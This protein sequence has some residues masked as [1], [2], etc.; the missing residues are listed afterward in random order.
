[1]YDKTPVYPH[2]QHL[3]FA[4]EPFKSIYVFQRL[5]TTILL[6]PLWL[7]YY[8][9]LP[10]S[11]RP[12]PSW[13]ITQI[14]VVKFTKR[15]YKVTE[16]AGVTWGTRD[17]TEEPDEKSLDETRF[18]WVPSLPD[19]LCTGI[20]DDDQVLRQRVGTFIWPKTLPPSAR[21]RNVIKSGGGHSHGQNVSLFKDIPDDSVTAFSTPAS[22]YK[23]PKI[24]VRIEETLP[25][26]GTA[27]NDIDVEA[28][29]ANCPPHVIGLYLHGGGYCHMSAHEKSGTS[30]IPRRL[31]K[32]RI[33]IFGRIYVVM[34]YSNRT[35]SSK[36]STVRSFDW[37]GSSTLTF[38]PAVEYRLIQHAPVPGAIQDAAAVYAHLV[39]HH[40]GARKG[41]DGKYNYPELPTPNHVHA[42]DAPTLSIVQTLDY[43]TRPGSSIPSDTEASPF[44][45]TGDRRRVDAIQIEDGQ[46]DSVEPRIS[47]NDAIPHS[48]VNSVHLTQAKSDAAAAAVRPHII[49]IGD[50]AG[51]NLVLALA[52]WIRDEGVLPAPDGILLL[53]PSCDPCTYRHMVNGPDSLT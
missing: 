35:I 43:E 48:P 13:S 6:V 5:L 9:I 20:V 45:E 19:E 14:I 47:G 53:S 40:L 41:P 21:L 8:S 16:V 50:S 7:V 33:A 26:L 17:P 36:R 25:Y 2:Q 22:Q 46:P 10:R 31:M 4:H 42:H 32:V 39:T 23:L 18:A 38:P 28:D 27:T 11:F 29:A 51:G 3:P 34:T 52:R 12:R 37:D 30:R 44:V 1:M 49:L 15:I 24:D